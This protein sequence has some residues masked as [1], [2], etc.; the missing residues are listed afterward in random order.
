M[1]LHDDLRGLV[2]KLATKARECH[3]LFMRGGSFEM[4]A[5]A[6]AYKSSVQELSAILARHPE[7]EPVAW[8]SRI[9]FPSDLR[10]DW[11]NITKEQF[12]ECKAEGESVLE[13]R[14]LYAA[15]P[16]AKE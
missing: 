6:D 2:E 5:K 1:T 16:Y 9:K 15:P 14:E 7:A 8:Q 3:D 11:T 13:L 4:M 10:G 12:A